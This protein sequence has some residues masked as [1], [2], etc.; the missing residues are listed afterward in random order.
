MQCIEASRHVLVAYLDARDGNRSKE[1]GGDAS[2]DTCGSVGK[3][4]SN[5]QTKINTVTT[6]FAYGWFH[7]C[8]YEGSAG[9]YVTC[10][11]LGKCQASLNAPKRIEIVTAKQMTKHKHRDKSQFTS[12]LTTLDNPGG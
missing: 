5:L 9:Q 6:I 4:G 2:N 12:L 11:W 7:K 3:E 10:M 1:E 8:M